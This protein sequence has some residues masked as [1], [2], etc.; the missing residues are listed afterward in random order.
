MQVQTDIRASLF[1]LLCVSLKNIV[2]ILDI[3]ANG[4]TASS[5]V[6]RVNVRRT[7]FAIRLDRIAQA[8]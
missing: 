1:T 7:A 6:C 3:P 5:D 4:A 8:S 2:A